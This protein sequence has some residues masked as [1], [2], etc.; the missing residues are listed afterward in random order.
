[1]IERVGTQLSVSD[2][3]SVPE[4]AFIP[5]S[6]V[7][8]RAAQTSA[9]IHQLDGSL[10]YAALLKQ[11]EHILGGLRALGL[12]PQDRVIIQTTHAHFFTSV[13]WGCVLGGIVPVPLPVASRSTDAQARLLYQTWQLCD[14]PPII[15]E[16]ALVDAIHASSLGAFAAVAV[17]ELRQATP[18]SNYHVGQLDD[19]ALMLMTS[20]STGNPKGVMLSARNLLASA[21]GMATVNQLTAE[22]IT[23][24]WMPLEHVASLVM[25]HFTPAYLGCE[26]IHVPT[27]IILQAPLKWLDLIEQ[28]RVTATWAP[29]FAYGLVNSHATTSQQRHWDL[30]SVRWMGNGAEAVVGRTARRFSELLA[31]HGLASSAISPGYGMSETCSGIAHSRLQTGDEPFVEVGAPIPGVCLRIVDADGHLVEAGTVGLLQ[32]RGATVTSGYYRRPDLNPFTDDGWFDTGDLGFL[33]QGRLTITGRQ[34]DTIVINSANYYSHE[35]EAVVEALEGVAVSY[36]AAC[37]VRGDDDATERLALFCHPTCSD[38]SLI[39]LIKTIRRTVARKIGAVPNYV[40]PVAKEAIPKTSLGKIQRQQLSQRFQHGEFK[41]IVQQ[42]RELERGGDRLPPRNDLERQIAQIWQNV[43][44]IDAA[45]LTDNFFELGGNSLLL[46]QV[47]YQLHERLQRQLS[48]VELFQYPTIEALA[49]YLSQQVPRNLDQRRSLRQRFPRTSSDIAVIGMACRF[50]GAATVDQF[51][52]NLCNGIESITFFT[53]AE[54]AKSV[55]QT[56]LNHPHYVKASPILDDIEF[57]DAEFFGY[58][59]K[60]AKL[61]DPQQRLLLECAWESLEDAGYSPLTYPGAIACYAG[62]AA[63]TYFLNNVYPNRHY[64]DADSDLQVFTLSSTGGFQATVANDKDYLTT[65]VSY[66]LNLTGPSVNVQTACSTSLVAV[67][68]ASQSLLTG[69]CDMALAGG[70]SV[71]V[72]QVGYLYQEGTIFSADGH[73][74]AFDANAQ[75]TIFGSGAGMVVLKRLEEAVADGD[76]I[77]A[78]IKGSAINND[79]G[80][81]VG[82]LAPN[83]EGQANVVA[84]ALAVAGVEAQ[85][86]SYVEAHGTGTILG[87]PIEVAALTQA[88]RSGTQAVQK[89]YCALGSVKTN[90]GHLQI[91]SGIAGFIKTV[92]ALHHKQLPPSLHFNTPNPQIDFANSPF[93]VNTARQDWQTDYPRR[94]G[95]NSLGIGGTNAHVILEEAPVRRRE[96]AIERPGHLLALS[97]RSE[98][99]LRELVTRYGQFLQQTEASTADI[100]FTVNTGRATFEHRLA[101]VATSK[102]ELRQQLQVLAQQPTQSGR[103]IANRQRPQIAFL[104]TGQ[105]S[106][107]LNMGQEL[108]ETQS[109]FRTTL[110]R[111]ATFLEPDLDKPLLEIY[112]SAELLNQTVYAQPALFALEYALA[113]LWISWG[114]TP[115]AVLGH[116]LGEYVAACVGGVFSLEAALKLV[117]ARGR[118]M[119][120]LPQRGIMVAVAASAAQVREAIAPYPEIAI[121]AINAPKRVVVS[122]P[123]QAVEKAIACLNGPKKVLPGPCAFHSPLIEPML[124]QFEQVASQ[125]EYATPRLEIVSTVTGDR[126]GAEIATP[127]YWCRQIRSTVRFADGIKTLQ[128][129]GTT[130]FLECGPQPTL[131]QLGRLTIKQPDCHWLPSL[132][133]QRSP[134]QTI[135]PTLAQLYV[136]G[137]TID[138]M[139]FNRGYSCSRVSLPTY[140]FQRQRYWIEPPPRTELKALP[141][142]HPLLGQRT[143]TAFKKTLF[144]AELSSHQPHYLQDH[145]V[146]QQVILPGSAYLEMALAAGE[147]NPSL[148][149][150]NVAIQQPLMLSDRPQTVQL[151]LHSGT[152]QTFEIYSLGDEDWRLH[153]SGNLVKQPPPQQTIDLAVRSHLEEIDVAAHYRHCQERGIDYGLS[154]RGIKKLWGRGSEALGWIERPDNVSATAYQ[155]HP[156]LLDACCQVIL[157]LLPESPLYLP[158]AV[159]RLRYYRRP[160]QH[161]WSYVR[162]RSQGAEAVVTADVRLFDE[163]G[164]I[165]ELDGLSAKRAS[166]ER[167]S[168][169]S[170]QDLYQIEWRRQPLQWSSELPKGKW[171]IFADRGGVAQQL[172]A[173]FKQPCVLVDPGEYR[174]TPDRVNPDHREDFYRLLTTV[175]P[176]QGVIHLWSLDADASEL[177]SPA[178]RDRENLLPSQKSSLETYIKHSCGST[179]H[180]VQ[181]LVQT[182]LNPRLWL[183]TQGAQAV[184]GRGVALAQSCLWGMAGA[185]AREHPEFNCVQVDLDPQSGSIDQLWAEIC[186]GEGE[187]VAFRNGNRYVARLVHPREQ[188]SSLQPLQ[189]TSN[190]RGTLDNLQWQPSARSQPGFGEVTVR[191]RAVGLNFRDVLNALDLY[192]GDPGALGLECT[193]EIVALGQGVAGFE[194][195]EAVV[196][197][198]PG[199]FRELVTVKAALVVPTKLSFATAAT[200][201]VAFSTAFYTLH[202][203]AKMRSGERV[204]IHAAA[205]GVGQA[206]VQMAQQAGAEV[207]ATASPGKWDVLRSLGVKYVM[208]S[209]TLDFADEILALTDGEGVDIVLNSLAG[210]FI[211]K[212]LAVLRSGGRFVE[213]GKNGVWSDRQVAQVRP[214]VAYFLVD[215]VAV[216]Q[217]QPT[218]IQGILNQVMQQIEDGK[219]TPLPQQVFPQEETVTA[220]RTMQQ[221]QH[222]GKIVVTLPERAPQ[223]TIRADGSYLITGGLGA[224]GLHTAQW[225]AEQGAKHLILVGRSQ[226]SP[227]AQVTV[228]QLKHQVQIQVVQADVSNPD[229]VADLMKMT[230]SLPPLRGL[231]HAAGVLDDGVLQQQSWERFER[232]MAPKVRGAWNLHVATQHHHLDFFMLY[233]SAASLLGAAGQ[234]NYAAA[235]AFLDALAHYRHRLGLP[236]LS[237]NWGAWSQ[238]GLATHWK[239]APGIGTIEP[240][241]ALDRLKSL[242]AYAPQVGVIPIDWSQRQPAMPFF[243]DLVAKRSPDG[244]NLRSQLA[245][246][247]PQ[248]R[249]EL[250]VAHLCS[251]V[252][253]ILDLQADEIELQQGFTELG[254]DSL[255]SVE[256]R[257]QLQKSLNCSL[258]T[259]ITFDYPTVTAL[260]DYLEQSLFP[261]PKLLPIDSATNEIQQ[262][263]EYEAEALLLDELDNLNY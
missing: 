93:Y 230:A 72:P 247:M 258:S 124:A 161:L 6:K 177:E 117:A 202:T 45:G 253:N 79:G 221:A 194:I 246:A 25:F 113:Q 35:I 158:V 147:A 85:T 10:P 55:E 91:A 9:G 38:D 243:A 244:P 207:F 73:C 36:T 77:Y 92:L 23:L 257:N 185:I 181:A 189:L 27:E 87:D 76:R 195:G 4:A 22:D 94:A 114:V 149:L 123:Q 215:L 148:M 48:V 88:F 212:S 111:C 197:I 203:L 249:R 135:L 238:T 109:Q 241:Q 153:C 218:L 89:R 103:G 144:T 26:Q 130:I 5:L 39:N 40:I 256:L 98:P 86:I 250:L 162:L 151:V 239:P 259:P 138:W 15:T 236:G 262:L 178:L 211:D 156:A 198:A 47:L 61:I 142:T 229:E 192:P 120:A 200:I 83:G 31:P 254:L 172:A 54:L 60:E 68:L 50:P 115:S 62:A 90:V 97:A 139:S 102:L 52:Q 251:Q 216:T 119:Q 51:W 174:E 208:N 180:L 118:L 228:E 155:L 122:G 101:V 19:V 226:P 100:C 261:H 137:A 209:R 58:S 96:Q 214:D 132:H 70:V 17:E 141:A 28:Y 30:S 1:M 24:N 121:A 234:A 41:E 179:L 11:A 232:V 163:A 82:Y 81:K 105:G 143:P 49:Q 159:E 160:G 227:D 133:P 116:S 183:V 182:G 110:E 213:I 57:F 145:R 106:Q 217:Q 140:P 157:A 33:R 166:R 95:V 248:R 201:P 46:M 169:S 53:N 42:I 18:D 191:A 206:A 165:A 125:I 3:G 63:N 134:W 150:E 8:Q 171:L 29:N 199:C 167:L 146:Y 104:F 56:L 186:A 131:I 245:A 2:G 210:D 231:I 263:S 13:F 219:L 84:Q 233:S 204:L 34:K 129:L 65:R 175:G 188:A 64:L 164:A 187:R 168:G 127:Q 184:A 170:S 154:F 196:A 37:A 173:K 78:V 255:S 80:T 14:R 44:K 59:P 224:L 99:A 222:I 69:E 193:G 136:Q 112:S 205:G 66:K 152:V 242:L 20:G 67:H 75:G 240:Q 220:F 107:S 237:I 32:V 176:I 16:Q 126:I 225:L 12:K 108:S 235:N 190:P 71:H 252:A 74:R 223:L 43:L 7:L 21:Y 260:A 128:Q